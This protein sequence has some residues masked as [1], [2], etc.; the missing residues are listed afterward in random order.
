VAEFHQEKIIFKKGMAGS[1]G[2][3]RDSRDY[4]GRAS[5]RQQR[6]TSQAARLAYPQSIPSLTR[7]CDEKRRK[8]IFGLDFTPRLT[9]GFSGLPATTT[10]GG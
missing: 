7:R 6:P 8:N 2:R 9:R 1:K 3:A 5:R 10:S 4:R